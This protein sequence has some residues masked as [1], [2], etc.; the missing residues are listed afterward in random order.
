MVRANT[1]PFQCNLLSML[2]SRTVPN[3]CVLYVCRDG[4]QSGS[5]VGA[6]SM[7]S[8]TPQPPLAAQ[9]CAAAQAAPP[10]SYI[11]SPSV[12]LASTVP[13]AVPLAVP[14][15]LAIPPGRP[16]KQS[17]AFPKRALNPY[18]VFLRKHEPIVRAE[19]PELNNTQVTRHLA[20]MWRN[21]SAEEKVRCNYLDDLS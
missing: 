8:S 3:L 12:P 14:T 15:A 17:K 19:Q 13:A 20:T 6:A 10:H 4:I 9:P 2:L 18:L 16:P 11:P 1:S 5:A 7:P 21:V